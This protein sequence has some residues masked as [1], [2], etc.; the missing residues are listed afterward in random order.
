M[1]ELLSM[2][3]GGLVCRLASGWAHGQR[4]MQAGRWV[5]M[6]VGHCLQASR[7]AGRQLGNVSPS[8]AN[9]NQHA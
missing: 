6:Q 8:Y 2:H 3:A 7:Q 5:G 1:G 9:I 4:G